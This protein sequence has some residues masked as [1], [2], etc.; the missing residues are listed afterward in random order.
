MI[1]NPNSYN[2][3]FEKDYNTY[4]FGRCTIDF[5]KTFLLYT[6]NETSI[7]H[8][9]IFLTSVFSRIFNRTTIHR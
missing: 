9:H 1:F 5:K 8:D 6:L 4:M 2:I 7:V 3:R